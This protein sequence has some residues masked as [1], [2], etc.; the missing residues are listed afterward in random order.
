M[1][2]LPYT[3]VL[4]AAARHPVL[5][6]GGVSSLRD[7]LA[8][9]L[10][11]SYG[12]RSLVSVPGYTGGHPLDRVIILVNSFG[13][14]MGLLIPLGLIYSYRNL[15][16]YFWFTLLAF[17][18]VGPFFVWITNLNLATAPSALYV[19]ERFFMLSYVVLA[20]LMALGIV[21]IAQLI[22]S[23]RPSLPVSPLRLVAGACLMAVLVTVFVKF[24]DIDQSHN[25]IARAFGEDVFATV[26]PGTILLATGD[27]VVLPLTYLRTVEG[28]RQDVILIDA[29]PTGRL[30]ST[31]ITRAL[32]YPE[33]TI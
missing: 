32:F 30:V 27:S 33:H 11:R 9:I 15:R 13:P 26:E 18:C 25:H 20:S 29:S 3:Y 21:M 24:R 8:L 17:V 7:L 22:S 28:L 6:W 14:L 19:L 31:P 5:N 4:W 2:L 16:W 23:H 1:A 10:R 12:T